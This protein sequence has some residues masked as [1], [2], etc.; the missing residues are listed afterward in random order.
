MFSRRRW[1]AGLLAVLLLASAVWLVLRF[2]G[3]GR[4]SRAPAYRIALLP[5]ENL[6][7]TADFDWAGAAIDASIP[8]QLGNDGR[9]TVVVASD[10]GAAVALQATHLLYGSLEPSY[11][12]PVNGPPAVTFTFVV[13]DVK[14]RSAV[15]RVR[16]TGSIVSAAIVATSLIADLAGVHVVRGPGVSTDAAFKLFAAGNYRQCAA[17]DPRAAWCWER[18][19]IS[20]MESGSRQDALQILAQARQQAAGFSPYSRARL[21]LIQAGVEGRAAARL[22]ALERLARA[23]PENPAALEEYVSEL[24][25]N[26]RFAQAE[27]I[28]RN[29]LRRDPRQPHALNAM[30][31]LQ[32]WQN[33]FTAARR[34]LGQYDALDRSD[35]NPPDSLGEVE[36]IAGNLPAAQAAFLESYRR[37]PNFNSGSALD[38]AALSAYLAGDATAATSLSDKFVTARAQAGDP[39]ALYHRARWNQLLGFGPQ[40]E[41]LLRAE[42]HRGAA[43]AALCAFRLTIAALFSGDQSE[44]QT[45]AGAARQAIPHGADPQLANLAAA[46]AGS[47]SSGVADPRILMQVKAVTRMLHGE[48]AAALPFWDDALRSPPGGNDSLSRELKAWCLVRAGRAAEAGPLLRSGWPVLEYQDRLLFDLLVYPNLFFVRA[49]AA[50]SSGQTAEARRLY[51]IYLRYSGQLPDRFGQA[52]AAKVAGRL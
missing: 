25:A 52:A 26:R 29:A 6:T 20:S 32:A 27:E 19:A 30:A 49:A 33:E 2:S 21:D 22:D 14:T 39:L 10:P 11:L 37:N 42:L 16:Q 3:V 5:V 50:A 35:P 13:E 23:E 34:T 28:Y 36:W 18:W 4:P 44:A 48:F 47:D 24:T 17:L 12:T 43:D 40:A 41:A 15:A 8:L 7:G 45:F 9:T 38:K 31:Y 1:L 51:D 46:L